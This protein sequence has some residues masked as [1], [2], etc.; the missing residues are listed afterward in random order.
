M[1]A[2]K[3]T[4]AMHGPNLYILKVMIVFVKRD[5]MMGGYFGTGLA[6]LKAMAQS[7]S[8]LLRSEGI[9]SSRYVAIGVYSRSTIGSRNEGSRECLE[10]P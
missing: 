10:F 6:N 2:S 8:T 4:W 3:V 9:S 5:R 7:A 1:A